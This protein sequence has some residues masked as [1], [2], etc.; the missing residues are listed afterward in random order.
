MPTISEIY[1]K[2]KE[3]NIISGIIITDLI[4]F[5][6]YIIF[7]SGVFFFGDLHTLIG[8]SIGVYFGLSN[9]KEEQTEFKTGLYIGIFGGLLVAISITLYELSRFTIIQ[10]FSISDLL[11]YLTYFLTE[12]L[13]LGLIIGISLSFYFHR[14]KRKF[15]AVRKYDEDLYKE[16][17]DR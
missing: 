11:F 17:E 4:A 5:L 9:R 12:C 13:I 10:G 16:L 14:K 6:T 7:P 1:E 3:K 2:A 8:I 15:P